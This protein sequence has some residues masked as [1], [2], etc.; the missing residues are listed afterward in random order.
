MELPL[1]LQQKKKQIHMILHFLS[2]KFLVIIIHLTHHTA[3][4]WII[5]LEEKQ[6]E[7]H[8]LWAFSGNIIGCDNIQ[9]YS[10][11]QKHLEVVHTNLGNK[12]RICKF[13]LPVEIK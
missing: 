12:Q 7:F 10:L 3:K 8:I 5:I 4:V 11:I 6:L 2:N 1:R 13:T 9:C